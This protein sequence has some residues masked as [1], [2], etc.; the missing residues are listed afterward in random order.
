[1]LYAGVEVFGEAW[2][3]EMSKQDEFM[4]KLKAIVATLST[5]SQLATACGAAANAELN[6]MV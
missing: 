4:D 6:V 1:M 3:W 5:A 2:G